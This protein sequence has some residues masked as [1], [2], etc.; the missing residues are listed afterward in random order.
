MKAQELRDIAA[1]LNRWADELEGIKTDGG[2]LRVTLPGPTLFDAIEQAA[3][4]E[5]HRVMRVEEPAPEPEPETPAKRVYQRVGIRMN[6]ALLVSVGDK[7][8]KATGFCQRN[9]VERTLV[10]VTGRSREDV[11]EA[12]NKA[13][14]ELRL[15]CFRWDGY[16]YYRIIDRKPLID[17]AAEYLKGI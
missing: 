5:K 8:T 4:I 16:R 17:L 15:T 9:D 2:T 11:R 6:E 14:A 12:V 10:R 13:A 3:E 1:R 7:P